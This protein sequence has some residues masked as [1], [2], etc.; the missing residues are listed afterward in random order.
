[1]IRH[2]DVRMGINAEVPVGSLTAA[3]DTESSPVY[4]T[5]DP[6]FL[7]EGHGFDLAPMLPIAGSGDF[8]F[9]GV[10]L[11]LQD[12][13]PDRWGRHLLLRQARSVDPLARL[14]EVDYLSNVSDFARQGALRLTDPV[15]G[16]VLSDTPV[17][18]EL[19]LDVLLDAADRA[20]DDVESFTPFARLL[21][22][23]TS[24]L[25]GARPKA[26][27]IDGGDLKIAKFPMPTDRW[28]VPAWEQVTLDLAE[29]AGIERPVS[30]LVQVG[31]RGVVV[32]DRFDRAGATRVPY[33]SFSTPLDNPDDG[34]RPPDYLDVVAM[35]RRYTDA[36]LAEV[37]RR[38]VFGVLMNN[39]DD[40]LRNMGLLRRRE[41]WELAPMFDVNPEPEFGRPRHTS[42]AGRSTHIGIAEALGKLGDACRLTA[43]GS[44]TAVAEV[45]DATADWR[46]VAEASGI[47]G[48]EVARMATVLDAVRAEVLRAR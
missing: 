45:A 28:N 4:F 21:E 39:T 36:D 13:G 42:I 19:T 16:E 10:P 8:T 31:G 46:E 44:I 14:G 17:P 11:F 25:G 32:L 29:R 22:T 24:A 43:R 30:R 3:G 35:L 12:A 37:F 20:A 7:Y 9:A 41:R 6:S 2:L 48:P 40:H 47:P 1:M 26:S 33:M 18:S 15:S 5:Y 38:V 34:R 23:G 27:V